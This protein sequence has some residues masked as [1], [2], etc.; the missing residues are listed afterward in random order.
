[1]IGQIEADY[2]C[3]Q[4]SR[5]ISNDWSFSLSD[6]QA[7]TFLKETCLKPDLLENLLEW[8]SY[9]K[10]LCKSLTAKTAVVNLVA[11]VDKIR[12]ELENTDQCLLQHFID[13]P[14][15]P[16]TK[17]KDAILRQVSFVNKMWDRMWIRSPALDGTLQRAGDRYSKFLKLF[18][19]YPTKMFVPT[20]D[21]DLVWHT[22]QCSPLRYCMITQEVAGKFVNHD[23]S[24]VQSELDTALTDTRAMYR[25]RFGQEYLV[26]GCWDC[27]TLQSAVE[28]LGKDVVWEDV[29]AKV[30]DD[31]AYYRAVEVARRKKGRIP[32]R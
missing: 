17:L 28:G 12:D 3:L 20:L 14:T 24:I 18:K 19:L 27:E 21:I 31:V 23:D 10:T 25:M 15:D 32:I 1:M 5:I 11:E 7:A 22:H 30:S 26:C 9:G 4:H 29:A 13:A 8:K 6:S 2:E 16:V